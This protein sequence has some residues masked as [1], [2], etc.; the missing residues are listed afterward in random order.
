VGTLRLL[1]ALSVVLGHVNGLFGYQMAGGRF[2]VQAFFMISGFYMGLILDGQY[3]HLSTRV[4]YG[5]RFLRIFPVYWVVM[6]TTLAWSALC[7]WRFG[8]WSQLQLYLDYWA[9]LPRTT[10]A[11]L[12]GTNLLLFGHETSVFMGLDTTNGRLFFTPDFRQT[13]PPLYE[14][15]PV[16]QAWTLSLE[17]VFYILAPFLMRCGSALLAAI[18]AFSLFLRAWIYWGLGWGHDPWTY[19]FL[20]TE[21]AF[22]I[23]GSLAYRWYRR[24]ENRPWRAG[25]LWMLTAVVWGLVL[26]Y[27]FLPGD[28][29]R[30]WLGLCLL[31]PAL[32]VVF[33]A[34]RE[35]RVDRFVGELS[36]P[37][38]IVHV[39]VLRVMS[40][41]AFR[42]WGTIAL[43]SVVVTMVTSL[44]LVL[45][46]SRPLERLR[47]ARLAK[48]RAQDASPRSRPNA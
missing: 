9:K 38:Y 19:R 16:P 47:H 5:N 44:L 30:P 12:L 7:G 17:L 10:L 20:P 11:W 13:S 3:A 36:Y 48:A 27:D 40:T 41:N 35:S 39:L 32:P 21:M 31:A 2:A 8:S 22:F 46:V 15:M 18:V 14:F 1:L 4:F 26:A 33:Q 6:I 23:A 45:L 24:A 28:A 43:R 42:G 25:P 37:V 34:T 29:A